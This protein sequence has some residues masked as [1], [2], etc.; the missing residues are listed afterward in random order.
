MDPLLRI[1]DANYNRAREALRVMED[2]ARFALDDAPLCTELKEIRHALRGALDGAGLAGADLLAA[3]D[4]PRDVGTLITTKSEQRRA[5]LMDV[6]NAAGARLTEALRALEECLKVDHEQRHE[7]SGHRARAA[8][9]LVESL[10]YRAYEAGRRLGLALGGGRAP[11]WRLCVLITES[12]CRGAWEEAVRA[13]IDGG[14]DCVQ[15]R[16][17]ELSDRELLRRARRVVEIVR[18]GAT[19]RSRAVIIN[20]RPEIAL[21]AGAD[22]VHLGQRDMSVAE[23]RRVA[24]FRLLIGVSTENLDQARA[25]VRDGAD[26]CGVGPMFPTTTKDKP[27]IA[28]PEYLAQYLADRVVSRVPHLAI[29]GI[30]PDNVGVLRDAGCRG[31]AVSAAVCGAENPEKVCRLLIEGLGV[32]ADAGQAEH[33]QPQRP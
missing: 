3:R 32:R 22:G 16:E 5:G 23:A 24:G 11:Q 6:V 21:L 18:E 4:T 28:G 8:A 33:P 29:G 9:A 27:R 31:V 17:K 1:L 7:T 20:N 12:L 19:D 2:V 30:T 13:V 10:R 15:L 26:Y 14:V 25:A